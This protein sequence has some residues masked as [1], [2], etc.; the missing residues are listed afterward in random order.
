MQIN[1]KFDRTNGH[2]GDT[3]FTAKQ[4]SVHELKLRQV[5]LYNH[6]WNYY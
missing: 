5:L 1:L 3:V 2:A 4:M 6:T